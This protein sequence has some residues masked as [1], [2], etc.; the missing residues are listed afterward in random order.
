MWSSWVTKELYE[1]NPAKF[2]EA[3]SKGSSALAILSRRFT[4]L[5][6]IIILHIELSTTYSIETSFWR[7]EERK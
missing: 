4:K 2:R 1:N 7:D 6:D 5:N 3:T